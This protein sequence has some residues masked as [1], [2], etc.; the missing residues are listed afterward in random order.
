MKL[1]AVSLLFLA[2]CAFA[3]QVDSN[4]GERVNVNDT[5][6][7]SP[8]VKSNKLS[9]GFT[10]YVS[11]NTSQPGRAFIR[12]NV[13]AG[14]FLADRDQ[15]S[16]VDH[17]VEHVLLRSSAHFPEG[18]HSL[19][20]YM[21]SKGIKYNGH[22]GNDFTEYYFDIP[23]D[24]AV[25]RKI[26]LAF[27]DWLS[28]QVTINDR[29]IG[30]E[31]KVVLEETNMMGRASGF[32]TLTQVVKPSEFSSVY[33]VLNSPDYE[34]ILKKMSPDAIKRFYKDWYRP[35][36]AGVVIT[37]DVN[38]DV[39]TKNV[40]QTLGEIKYPVQA[41]SPVQRPFVLTGENKYIIDIHGQ[42]ENGLLQIIYVRPRRA[43]TVWK[44]YDTVALT[45]LFNK[46]IQNRLQDFSERESILMQVTM[47]DGILGK[48]S[49]GVRSL[50]F[51]TTFKN[52]R[53]I[54]PALKRLFTEAERIKRLGFSSLELDSAK[55]Q[56]KA[57]LSLKAG[58]SFSEEANR[59]SEH[60]VYGEAAPE[61]TLM[62]SNQRK[63]LEE[64]T[65]RELNE[66]AKSWIMDHDRHIVIEGPG[67]IKKRDLPDEATALRWLS[68][69]QQ[70][71][72]LPYVMSDKVEKQIRVNFDS[73]Y[74]TPATTL[75]N[76]KED[77]ESGVIELLLMNG[78]H[79]NLIP[80]RDSISRKIRLEGRRLVGASG[81]TDAD[82]RNARMATW[83]AR[84]NGLGELDRQK[85]E[86]YI[87][88]RQGLS[89]ETEINDLETTVRGRASQ[90]DFETLLQLI[91]RHFLV[92]Q[93]VD[94]VFAA[95][96]EE[97]IR[98]PNPKNYVSKE[99]S[100]LTGYRIKTAS[101]P[102]L[103]VSEL[104]QIDYDKCLAAYEQMFSSP[105]EFTFTIT[106]VEDMEKAVEL[107]AKYL[108][109][110]PNHKEA[111]PPPQTIGSKKESF[112]F[113]KTIFIRNLKKDRAEVT[114]LYGG[115]HSFSSD[116]EVK[117]RILGKT[118]ETTCLRR[119]REKEAGTYAV[120][121]GLDT[122]CLPGNDSKCWYE[123][124]INF[125]CS[126][127]ASQRLINA[128][129]EEI[130][131]IKKNGPDLNDFNAAAR[132]Y[133]NATLTPEDI[134]QT[135]NEYLT[136]KYFASWTEL[137]KK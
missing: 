90:A 43:K 135:A 113:N 110:L 97:R 3:F 78:V 44:D 81:Y 63:F 75:S 35:D 31:K 2:T 12:L 17:I 98:Y 21:K 4:A 34:D 109:N 46:L 41:R 136:K 118:I 53:S 62:R 119:L 94:S 124:R 92:P 68:E 13:K 77:K 20:E 5:I 50:A 128:A 55:R 16:E 33:E 131:L 106:G 101:L 22:P 65:L 114:I 89:I 70:R 59:L 112:N 95:A 93:K 51:S 107:A 123:M 48:T 57:E 71:I 29:T 64:I 10:Y 111:S 60:F 122:Q 108:G 133:K 73:L 45:T 36:L 87:S 134:Q 100:R 39:I 37:G 85:L 11:R 54:E 18:D 42:R 84:A 15:L 102:W 38:V 127:D 129:K 72:I 49:L 67:Q 74:R 137:G 120:N 47:S 126:P 7:L 105:Q 9:N 115:Y 91:Y 130:E 80:K 27:Q 66:F 125:I 132:D 88:K 121:A 25:V 76:R 56:S 83:F 103:S 24:T 32:N 86:L 69:V 99:L 79:V 82:Y 23:A 61:I 116:E 1:V 28:G 30:A 58:E 104:N 6:P 96:L 14:I 40:K 52:A 8:S 19:R 26:L 117:Q